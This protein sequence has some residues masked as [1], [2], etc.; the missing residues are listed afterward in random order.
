MLGAEDVLRLTGHEI[1]GVCPFGLPAPLKIYLDQSLKIYDELIPAAGSI[2]ASIRL[3]LK[4]LAE[5]CGDDWVDVCVE[6][7]G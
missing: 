3:P 1:G 6:P 5:L 2:N 4:R 7:V